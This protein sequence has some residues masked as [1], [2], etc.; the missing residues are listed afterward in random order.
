MGDKQPHVEK[1]IF[2]RETVS[3]LCPLALCPAWGMSVRKEQGPAVVELI[4]NPSTQR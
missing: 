3:A 2:E 4:C 1:M